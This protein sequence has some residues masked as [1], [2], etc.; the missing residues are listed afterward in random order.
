MTISQSL[1]FIRLLIGIRLFD[2]SR[3]VFYRLQKLTQFFYFLY[4][5]YYVFFAEEN[6]AT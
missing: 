3:Y 1:E 6:V 5:P 2:Q 4:L